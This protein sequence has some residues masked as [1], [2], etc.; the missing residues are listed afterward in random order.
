[1]E[2]K[3]KKESEC[4]AAHRQIQQLNE[5]VGQL[6][7]ER[8]SLT[9]E[10]RRLNKVAESLQEKA[11]RF[12]EEKEGKLKALEGKRLAE[13]TLA[14]KEELFKKEISEAKSHLITFREVQELNE[15]RTGE[16]K[17]V[18]EADQRLKGEMAAELDVTRLQADN[19]LKEKQ[20]LFRMI[21]DL[22]KEHESNNLIYK[23]RIIELEE[24][25]NSQ[26]DKE[27]QIQI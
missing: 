24:A 13:E 26:K 17:A 7:D 27:M 4:N 1:M 22:K 3:D 11:N 23:D 6:E 8:E 20:E 16:L 14:E 10:V 2:Y 19:L 21:E 12:E 25:E 9:E 18:V 15:I 5:E